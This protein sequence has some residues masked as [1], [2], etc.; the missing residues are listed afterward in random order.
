MSS[1]DFDSSD[2]NVNGFDENGAVLSDAT[3]NIATVVIRNPLNMLNHRSDVVIDAAQPYIAT[4]SSTPGAYSQ[5]D[6][7]D[8]ALG[9]S[10]PVIMDDTLGVPDL[11]LSNGAI[12]HYD[13]AASS[14]T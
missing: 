7:I 4:V 2:L 9:W 10:K 5:G 1:G 12:A 6:V 14:P 3:G 13:A 11:V 8:I